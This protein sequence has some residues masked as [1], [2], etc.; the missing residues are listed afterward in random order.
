MPEQRRQSSKFDWSSGIEVGNRW[1]LRSWKAAAGKIQLKP[2]QTGLLLIADCDEHHLWFRSG[3]AVAW[4][5]RRVFWAIK[6]C[7]FLG[8]GTVQCSSRSLC[9]Q[10]FLGFAHLSARRKIKLSSSVGLCLQ[11]ELGKFR[12]KTRVCDWE[13]PLIGPQSAGYSSIAELMRKSFLWSSRHL[14]AGL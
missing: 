7:K 1:V 4:Q 11:E 13:V 14:R 6:N 9:F 5:G 8:S 3:L 2:T 10:I 12:T